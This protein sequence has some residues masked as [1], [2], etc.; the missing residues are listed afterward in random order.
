ML[1][2]YKQED[3]SV[4]M[5]IGTAFVRVKQRLIFV[6]LYRRYES[7]DTATLIRKELETWADAILAKNKLVEAAPKN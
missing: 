7:P 1:A 4:T 3:R 2:A 5:I 6:Y